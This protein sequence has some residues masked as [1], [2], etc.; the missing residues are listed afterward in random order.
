MESIT[1]NVNYLEK[2]NSK[3]HVF[4]SLCKRGHDHK[5]GMS[6]RHIHSGEKTGN[7]IQ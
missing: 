4:G 1:T 7:C 3:F 5:D 6:I 2:F